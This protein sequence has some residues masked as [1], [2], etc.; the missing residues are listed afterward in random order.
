MTDYDHFHVCIAGAGVI[1][2]AIAYQISHSPA[3]AGRRLLLLETETGFGQHTSS[4]NSEVIHAG[5][6][7]PR[8][9]L[10]ARYCVR[11]KHLLYA[12]CA[13]HDIPHRRLGK[14]ILAQEGEQ[15]A[16]AALQGQACANG[17]EDLQ[18][19]DH[20]WLSREQPALQA[21][22]ALWSPSSGIVDSHA[23]M[24]SLLQQAEMRGLL[25]APR[26]C[27]ERVI[28]DS[29]GFTVHTT[30]GTDQS[31]YR[32]RCDAFINSA[33][34]QAP[35]LARRIESAAPAAPIPRLHLCKGDYFRY[36]GPNPLNCLVYPLP[37]ANTVGLGVHA[38]L[39]LGGQLR[40]GPDTEFVDV[41]SYEIDAGKADQFAAA[42]AR[43]LPT[44]TAAQLVPDYAGL[45]P[46]LSG[47][48]GQAADF[49]LQWSPAGDNLLQLFGID[50]PG[51]TASL[52]IAEAVEQR[53]G[54][55]LA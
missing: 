7:Y 9:S 27:V 19:R 21:A 3:F 17:V 18:W 42:I 38:T 11:G 43:Y 46:K 26:T 44:V 30:I 48:G 54:A 36:L 12:Y 24:R 41:P 52:A 10:K 8:D 5:I 50:S 2:L 45:R 16:L 1:G 6:Y 37:E 55:S 28:A 49:C 22:A 15:E 39:D 25:F 33:G 53:L 29:S 14:L 13:Q 51:L 20:N 32:L 47:P 40:F 23:L 35:A 31:Q 4:R 34:L